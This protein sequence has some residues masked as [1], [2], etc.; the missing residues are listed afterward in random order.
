MLEFVLFYLDILNK[1]HKDY[2]DYQIRQA[3]DKLHFIL[4]QVEVFSATF[5]SL[6]TLDIKAE[7]IFLPGI[8]L[9]YQQTRRFL[10]IT[11]TNFSFSNLPF[12]Y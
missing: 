11:L 12:S 6:N 5:C 3:N 8:T 2:V 10:Y 7:L 4:G 1:Q 9:R